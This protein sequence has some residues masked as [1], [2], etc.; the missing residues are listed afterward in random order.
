MILYELGTYVYKKA[1]IINIITSILNK[2]FIA[3]GDGYVKFLKKFDALG[4]QLF[5]FSV[6]NILYSNA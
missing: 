3:C 5:T 6:L 2:S 4:K 1:Y